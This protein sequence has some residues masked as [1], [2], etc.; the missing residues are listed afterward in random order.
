MFKKFLNKAQR[1]VEVWE[2]TD[3]SILNLEIRSRGIKA[4]GSG[5]LTPA[6]IVSQVQ[7]SV[8]MWSAIGGKETE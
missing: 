8:D 5:C 1:H 3:P 7:K 4:S 6:E 2:S